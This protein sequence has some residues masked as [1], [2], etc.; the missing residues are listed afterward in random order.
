MKNNGA[1]I[2]SLNPKVS[3]QTP[4]FCMSIT[5]QLEEDGFNIF[6]PFLPVEVPPLTNMEV[7]NFY[8]FFVD[9]NWI[10][11]KMG[12]SE[13]GFRQIKHLACRNPKDLF[14]YASFV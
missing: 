11:T 3:E 6:D 9:N 13:H 4:K 2:C 5:E 8:K 1:I 12:R 14:T 7:E 10:T